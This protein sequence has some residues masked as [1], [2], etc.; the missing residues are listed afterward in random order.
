[1]GIGAGSFQQAFSAFPES[2]PGCTPPGGG[3]FT[4]APALLP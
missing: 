2:T 4:A 1:M 3:D